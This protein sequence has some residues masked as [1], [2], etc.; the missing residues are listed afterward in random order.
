MKLNRLETILS[1][2]PRGGTVSDIGTDH[3][4]VPFRLLEEN[5][6]EKAIAT[7]ISA[8][9]LEKSRQALKGHI[10]GGRAEVRL[11][12]GLEVLKPGETDTAILAGMGG[13]L[14]G[15][16]L[17]K[18]PEVTESI[19]RFIL[20]PMQGADELRKYLWQNGFTIE[21]EEIAVE[22]RRIYTVMSVIHGRQDPGD[23]EF[24]YTLLKNPSPRVDLFLENKRREYEKIL[25]RAAKIR[26]KHRREEK[27]RQV[28]ERLKLCKEWSE[29]RKQRIS[30]DG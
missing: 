8:P 20:Q 10:R 1:L 25:T 13:V 24:S 5:K 18:T 23:P 9:S 19:P 30:I 26:S 2:V 3:G 6:I 17:E 21:R 12:Y 16:I 14:I 29:W 4:F 22:G 11:G 15:E 27:I 7:D 28:N